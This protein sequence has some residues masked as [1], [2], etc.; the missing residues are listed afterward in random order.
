VQDQPTNPTAALLRAAET[1]A[2]RS[3]MIFDVNEKGSH[4]L[5]GYYVGPRLM[6]DLSEAVNALTP[7]KGNND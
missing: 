2:M 4:F 6:L 3:Q 7:K 1:V 5:V